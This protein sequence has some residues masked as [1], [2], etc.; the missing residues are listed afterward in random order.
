VRSSTYLNSLIEQDRRGLKLRIGPM[1][2]FKRFR[3]AGITMAGIELLCRI[4]QGQFRLNGL[5]LKD[6][7]MPDVWNAVLAA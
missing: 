7:S 3:T 5:C 6:R 1:L 2:G 4:R